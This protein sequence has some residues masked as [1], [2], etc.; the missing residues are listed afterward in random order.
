[1]PKVYLPL[2]LIITIAGALSA[3]QASG[4]DPE[5][6]EDEAIN[7]NYAYSAVLGAGYYSTPS[8]R[9]LVGSLPLSWSLAPI[10]ERNSLKI[11]F[12][13]TGGVADIFNDEGEIE[14]SAQLVTATF[15]PGIAWVH[16][17]TDN[18]LLVPAAQVGVAR[19]FEADTNAWLYSISLRSYA[20]WNLGKHKIGLG[21]RLVGAGQTI[22][23]SNAQT[24]FVLLESGVE[25]D[26]LVPWELGGHATSA[27]VYFL[28]QHYGHAANLE[29]FA[30][31]NV[32]LVNHY[33]LGLTFGFRDPVTIFRFIPLHR[34][35]I[36]VGRGNTPSG[37]EIKSITLNLGFPL[38]YD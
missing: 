33:K 29:A 22:E 31:E 12:P 15:F 35:G 11:L 8:G 28:W 19:D 38:S 27:G 20:W 3:P 16:K 6:P 23:G 18:W 37:N 14:I 36:A 24:G 5:Q 1:M 26:H 34:V 25:W 2:I 7:F 17:A 9:V 32:D 21:N 30:N 13:L 10:N 4:Q